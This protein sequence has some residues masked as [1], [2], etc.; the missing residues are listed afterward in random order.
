MPSSNRLATKRLMVE[1]E[2]LSRSPVPG[3][4]AGPPDDTENLFHWECWIDGP[5][6]TPFE[7][8]LF[9][10]HLDFPQDYPLSPPVMKFVS[11][12]GTG[13]GP[14]GKGDSGGVYHPNGK[15]LLC[16]FQVLKWVLEWGYDA[17]A[18]SSC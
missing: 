5:E 10:A 11:A 13:V 16:Y 3:I 14:D 15:D 1:Y 9:C 7:D 6:G 17:Y 12:G 4:L 2:A 8:G 18:Q